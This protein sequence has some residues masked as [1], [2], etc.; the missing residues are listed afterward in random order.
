MLSE[1]C[2]RRPVMTILMMVSFIAAGIF[3][4]RQLPVAAVPRV[5]FPTI[6]VTAALPGASPETMASSVALILEKQFSTIAGV[7][8]MTSTSSL[9]NTSIVLQ[10]DLNRNIDGAALDVQ[11]QISAALRRLPID[12]PAPPSFRKVNPADQPII[13]LSLAS[14]LAR[15]SDVDRFAQAAILPRISTLPGVAQVLV[16]GTQKYAVRIKADLDQLASRGLSIL[17]LQTALVNANSNRPVGSVNAGP[18]NTILEATGP[19][20][21]AADYMPVVVAWQNGAPVRVSDV[22]T[23][24][25]SV[26]NDRVASW[27]DGKRAIVLAVQR[28]PDANTVEVVNRIRALLPQIQSEAPASYELKVLNDRSISIR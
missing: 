23:A 18:R 22:A 7:S 9:G 26:E 24:I 28:Q 19:V 27:L 14:D 8:S 17:D 10:F 21:R 4:Y 13:F 12:L 6:Q 25:D 16:F 11:S 15:L 1:L 20:N 2:I 5:D 3:G